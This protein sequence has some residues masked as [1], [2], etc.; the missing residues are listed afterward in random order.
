MS[1]PDRSAEV[2][3]SVGQAR[4]IPADMHV[5]EGSIM[6]YTFS[7]GARITEEAALE[8]AAD[9]GFHAMAFDVIVNE[10]E[11]LHWHE[12]DAVTWVIDGVGALR[13]GDDELIEVSAGCRIDAPAG[14]L[15]RNLAGPPV[16]VVL[17]TNLP[18]QEWTTPIDKDPAERP[19]HL[20]V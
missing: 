7:Q 3:A 17:A 15:H 18:Y 8:Q 2:Y 5:G 10:D 4:P 14:F 13:N 19:Q 9:M 6:E 20:S 11:S 16:R 1:L 12:F